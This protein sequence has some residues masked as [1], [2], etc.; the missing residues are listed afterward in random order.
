M[1]KRKIIGASLWIVA[2]IF[3]LFFT[4]WRVKNARQNLEEYWAAKDCPTSVNCREKVDAI[5]LDSRSVDL[6]FNGGKARSLYE[7]SYILQVS[8]EGFGT[9]KI[10]IIGNPA[11]NGTPFDVPNVITL[12]SE[13]QIALDNLFFWSH[14]IPGDMEKKIHFAVP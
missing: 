13:T 5:I 9:Q 14:Y 12:G 7:T 2:C 3:V 10:K 6:K 8:T 1:G 4:N 11:T